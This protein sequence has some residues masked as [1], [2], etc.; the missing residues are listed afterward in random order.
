MGTIY[1]VSPDSC[2]FEDAYAETLAENE[3]PRHE[4][5]PAPSDPRTV[6]NLRELAAALDDIQARTGLDIPIHVDAA[7]GGFVAPFLQPGLEWDFRIRRVRS[8]NGS[9]HKYGLPPL[10]VGWAVWRAAD[11]THESRTP[12]TAFHHG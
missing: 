10:G 6:R 5:P 12:R 11:L 3:L 9:G 4:I 8:I 1:Q 7:S 2:R